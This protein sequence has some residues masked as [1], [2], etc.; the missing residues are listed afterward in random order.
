MTNSN[1]SLIT[2]VLNGEQIYYKAISLDLEFLEQTVINHIDFVEIERFTQK[3]PRYS[4]I[5]ISEYNF[6]ERFRTALSNSNIFLPKN[7][8]AEFP[9][10]WQE[11][12]QQ[13][14]PLF[15]QYLDKIKFQIKRGGEIQWI[16]VLS[17]AEQE[18]IYYE[19][20]F[21][22]KRFVARIQDTGRE[23]FK[24]KNLYTILPI[25]INDSD[26]CPHGIP[27]EYAILHPLAESEIE[28]E[29]DVKIEFIIKLGSAPDLKVTDRENKY[30]IEAQLRDRQEVVRLLDR[31][32][33][34]TIFEYRRQK[35]SF[36]PNS[37]QLQQ[38]YTALLPIKNVSNFYEAMNF[39]KNIRDAYNIIHRTNNKI[40]LFLNSHPNYL[41]DKL[42]N[43]TIGNLR[44]SGLID[45]VKKYLKGNY[46]L[47]G[48][49]VVEAKNFTKKL[50]M[51]LGKTYK[52]SNNLSL[53]SFFEPRFVEIAYQKVGSEYFLFLSRV[54]L[55]EDFQLNYLRLFYSTW[56]NN[57][58]LYQQE[59]YLW[60]YSRILLW[61]FEFNR[62]TEIDF[63]EHFRSILKYLKANPNLIRGYKQNAF[64]ALIYLFTFRDPSLQQQFCPPNSDE[65]NLAQDVLQ[66]YSD[67]NEFIKL[68]AVSE[69]KS[70]NEYFK[71]LLEGNSSQEEVEGLLQV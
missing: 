16:E 1:N 23:Y 57:Q 17:T 42:L 22:T 62:Q 28:R 18:H 13:N 40:D 63:Q 39:G 55:T 6:L 7:Q 31:I 65:Y 24:L 66:Q 43:T 51:F 5:L 37:E 50:I 29:L 71:E 70:L 47:K 56:I 15:G 41:S 25:K 58:P 8:L 44:T 20:D 33:T 52:L 67:R 54:A 2:E 69:D 64:L 53:S 30:K 45:E 10:I 60:G 21:E 35:N 14:F 68:K 26:Y 11:K 27:Q 36:I 19:G 9:Q 4:F 32:P 61:Y 34:E 38:F 46:N 12:Q 59:K 49:R 48:S 3:Y